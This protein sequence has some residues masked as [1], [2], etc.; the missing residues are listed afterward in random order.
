[1]DLKNKKIL[2]ELVLNSRI[3][4]SRLAKRV[5]LSREV[6]TYRINQLVS[7]GIITNFHAVIDEEKLGYLR[8]TCFIQLKGISPTKE[9]Q[10]FEFLQKN[11]SVTYAGTVIGKWNVVFD[12]IS[13]DRR[14]MDKII[15]EIQEK[16]K[17]NLSIFAIA[18]NTISGG[19]YPEKIFEAR[20]FPK[21]NHNK[22]IKID[23][24]DLRILQCLSDNSRIE[25]SEL[26]KKLNMTANAIKYRIQNLEQSG[27]IDRY[28]ISIDVQ[29]LDF[30]WYNI[31]V[32]LIADE[33]KVQ[34]FLENEKI[35]IYHYH[36]IGNENWDI[37]IGIIVKNS[38][39]LREFLVKFREKFPEAIKI[40]DVYIILDVLKEN[41]LPEGV[42]SKS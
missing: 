28:T 5:G 42:F 17:A 27:V 32:K 34:E 8:N 35:T 3:P 14:D 16:V 22:K 9:K 29:K 18:G 4:L 37:D 23:K 13:K 10:F 21:V 15:K 19:Y 36:Y 41:I 30:S 26:S 20:K 24:T 40:H 25:Y 38:E 31:Q 11:K 6:L 2:G 12:L 1:M 33:K 7:K 39:E